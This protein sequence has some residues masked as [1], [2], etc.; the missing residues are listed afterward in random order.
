MT[1]TAAPTTKTRAEQHKEKRQK[2]IELSQE[3]REI[4]KEELSDM[5]INEILVNVFYRDA[6]NTEFNTF[7]QWKEKGMKIKKGAKAFLVWGKKKE[8][9]GA[10]KQQEQR[11]QEAETY[12]YF[13]LCYL[14]S[15]NQVEPNND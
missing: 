8:G 11:E 1:A 5:S 6:D 7:N 4:Q 12:E 9:K 14:F 10:E 3:A 2:L 13:P 15:N